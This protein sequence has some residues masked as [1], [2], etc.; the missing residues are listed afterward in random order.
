M[1]G[2]SQSVES[3]SFMGGSGSLLKRAGGD[4]ANDSYTSARRRRSY[5]VSVCLGWL[6]RMAMTVW[7][8]GAYIVCI[9]PIRAAMGLGKTTGVGGN[10]KFNRLHLGFGRIEERTRRYPT[11]LIAIIMD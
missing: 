2:G 8:L 3:N 7:L 5:L 6:R 10:G 11:A 4:V 1:Y 9:S